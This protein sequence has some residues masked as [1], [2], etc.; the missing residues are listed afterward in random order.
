MARTKIKLL[1]YDE[2]VPAHMIPTV[3]CPDDPKI[4]IYDPYEKD[5]YWYRKIGF[6]RKINDE[7]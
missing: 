4:K 1:S 6:N 5:T 2:Y 7:E 3:S